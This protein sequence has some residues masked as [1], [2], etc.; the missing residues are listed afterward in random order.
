MSYK[1]IELK[2]LIP[3]HDGVIVAD[4]K[5]NERYTSGGIFIP[6]D[7]KQIHGVHSRWGRVYAVGPEQTE[8][9]VGQ[10]ILITH[11]R[12]TR[13][14]NVVDATGEHTVRRVD[15]NDILA[16]SDEEVIDETM[17]IPLTEAQ[18]NGAPKGGIPRMNES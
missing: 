7:D 4:M 18:M 15:N 16:V 13:G 2:S 10:W 8:I 14:V 5:F 1:A 9:K 6:S 3:L 11:G 12:W 17:G